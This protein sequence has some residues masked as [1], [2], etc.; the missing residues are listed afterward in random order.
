[1]LHIVQRM[2]RHHALKGQ[3]RA[4]V[5]NLFLQT[6]LYRIHESLARIM[7]QDIISRQNTK[8]HNHKIQILQRKSHNGFYIRR[9]PGNADLQSVIRN[10]I[11]QI[12]DTVHQIKKGSVWLIHDDMVGVVTLP[13]QFPDVSSIRQSKHKIGL[14]NPRRIPLC[15]ASCRR[16]RIQS[17]V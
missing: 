7:V 6:F 9:H 8:F 15:V 11:R 5:Y 4:L 2:L 13:K 12:H 3:P 16:F 1:M 17:A 14:V 10:K